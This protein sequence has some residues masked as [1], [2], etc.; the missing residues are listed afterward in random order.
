MCTSTPI[1]QPIMNMEVGFEKSV[2]L[3]HPNPQ[4]AF[5]NPYQL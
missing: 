4:T 2:F 3:T 1:S 5:K